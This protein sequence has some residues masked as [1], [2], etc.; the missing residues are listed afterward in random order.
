MLSDDKHVD[1][2]ADDFVHGLLSEDDANI[3][4]RH[5]EQCADC[6]TACER[7][8]ERK[9]TLESL[10]R[11]EASDELIRAAIGRAQSGSE[12]Q[13]TR[14]A[15]AKELRW[16]VYWS[17]VSAAAV[18]LLG[19]SI[20]FSTLR[21]SP[22]DLRVYGQRTLD[23]GASESLRVMLL[24]QE[25]ELPVE[26]AKIQIALESLDSQLQT[27]LASFTT[28]RHG[29]ASPE[30]QI[31]DWPAGRYRL[32]VRAQSGRRRDVVDRTIELRRAGKLM[33]SSD[34]PVYQPGQ[35]IHLRC[36]SLHIPDRTP[37]GGQVAEFT[38]R[39]PKG[40]MIFKH[41]TRTSRFGI[42]S[43]DCPLATELIEGSYQIGCSIG[44][45]TTS[46]LTV[47]V[48]PYVLP[49]FRVTASTD[50][51]YY[52]PGE[53]IR[54]QVNSR[55]FFGK[56]VA[57]DVDA[58]V[59]TTGVPTSELGTLAAKLDAE[60]DAELSLRLPEKLVGLPM[61]S[62]D[63]G[64]AV[65]IRVTDP[66]GQQQERTIRTIATAEPLRVEVVHES[67]RLV[68]GVANRIYLF[69]TYA[70]G[71]PASARMSIG[72]IP[73]EVR[74]NLLGVAM[75]ELTPETESYRL[76]VRA[77][78]DNELVA[79]E[80]VTLHADA[81]RDR[82]IMRTDRVVY[83][84]GD[85]VQIAILGSGQQPVF[86]DLLKDG[87][88]LLTK[89]VD[90]KDGRGQLDLDLPAELSGNLQL[91]GYRFTALDSPSLQ[92][93]TIVV[94]AANQVKLAATLD[95]D[96]YRPGDRATVKFQL[97]TE[98]G[99]PVVG[100]V[101]L[102]VVDEA[103]FSV[104][105]QRP[106]MEQTFF[107]LDS[108]LLEPGY[109]LYQSLPK[110]EGDDG[111]VDF[112]L[113]QQA[114]NARDNYVGVQ[115]RDRLRREIGNRRLEEITGRSGISQLV[116]EYD[117]TEEVA[118]RVIIGAAP[119]SLAARTY[120]GKVSETRSLR[121]EALDLVMLFWLLFA[122]VF[123]TGVVFFITR[124]LVQGMCVMGGLV[125]LVL[126]WPTINASRQF[127]SAGSA[128]GEDAVA[129]NT[130]PLDDAPA[131]P[132]LR[133]W[134][135]E[136]LM[137]RPEMITDER[138][139]L[140]VDVPLA[141][142]IT[143]WRL[144]ASAVTEAGL[145]GATDHRIRVFQPFFV[146]VNL[147]AALTRNDE[148]AVPVIVYNYESNAQAVELTLDDEP[149]FELLDEPTRR[150]QVEPG[151]VRSEYFRIRVAKVGKHDLTIQARSD[152][153]IGDAIKRTVRVNPN[154]QLIENVVSGAL[155]A[156]VEL[157]V[158][159]EADAVPGSAQSI[160]KVYPSSF[161]QLV[162]G[163]ESILRQ[164]H[165]CFEQTSSTTYPNV[166]ALDY[167]RRTE[168]SQPKVEAKARQYIH[169]GYQR[170]LTFEVSG[171][172]FDWFGNPPANQLLTA[173]GLMEFIDMAEVHDVDPAL[174][175]RTRQWLLSKRRDDGSWDPDEHRMHDDLAAATTEEMR[176]LK[177]TAYIAWAAFQ[178]DSSNASTTLQFLLRHEPAEIDSPY[179]LALVSNAILA[180]DPDCPAL[181]S[182]LDRLMSLR[183]GDVDEQTTYWAE[184]EGARTA[185]YGSGTA[186]EVEAT[187]LA[188]LAFMTANEQPS[189]VQQALS[190]LV[191]QKDPNGTWHSTQATVL[192]L[193]ALLAGT[194]GPVS[195][196]QTRLVELLM[197]DEV[198]HQFNIPAE[199]AEVVHQFVIA[200]D[201][202]GS[203]K[204]LSLR[205]TT[206]AS[207]AYQIVF[208]QH[209]EREP[210]SDVEGQPFKIDVQYDRTQLH[211]N[212]T[213]NATATVVN[214]TSANAPMLMVDL[215][216]PAGFGVGRDTLDRAQQNHEAI[217]KYEIT[218]RSIILYLRD[219]S[220]QE[221][222]Q[223]RYQLRALMPLRVTVPAARTYLYYDPS[224]K[225]EGSPQ[226]I[227]VDEA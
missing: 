53:M 206:G 120:P 5:C 139:Q 33:L 155:T 149:W 83:D 78:D 15:K 93:Q 193:K 171:G 75:I 182:Y 69:A 168:Q 2:Y 198:V 173:Y 184:P 100:A 144:T 227:V 81:R 4:R 41:R 221:S 38:I 147:P 129:A 111:S 181:T 30:M 178:A 68:P 115:Q 88:T 156:P 94:R 213:L 160:V 161:S 112:E 20:Y 118:K 96:E 126:L 116:R 6:Q 95:G 203:Q 131:M 43:T 194:Q 152:N 89:T 45:T 225:A 60:G 29:T 37:I 73:D 150:V 1:Q 190:W 3:F 80:E 148:V 216:I 67:G 24:N 145:L 166:L 97:S 192:A 56:S 207:T 85:T 153:G 7:A 54:I 212:E 26:D 195:S 186:G 141:D 12:I 42:A 142:S 172:G 220:S 218:P 219:L 210:R 189:I 18:L 196:D 17:A 215:P 99:Q 122:I 34:K 70:D 132:R 57:G 19:C 28:D 108:E 164:P 165:G 167:L 106:G 110:E 58:R 72:G 200:H 130:A 31:P 46:E 199:Q 128:V 169:L 71:Q 59:Y 87:Q 125:V 217:E 214:Q 113:V 124:T 201:Q 79:T 10:P 40:N 211:L 62:G 48:K 105:T 197:D 55:Y 127:K 25:T 52:R 103:V 208:R 82:F 16:K 35:T 64:I 50:R 22:Y 226:Q 202:V 76:R 138:G 134:F 9:E 133:E 187:A 27:R 157:P 104:M 74:T 205:E 117:L 136:T 23:A 176:R 119:H 170:L 121:R 179:V 63:L 223:I 140:V 102:A 32:V 11:P 86:I 123:V 175:K 177:T 49:K 92:T 191:A 137:W 65:D 84:G 109:V 135:P 183:L 163:L 107:E 39:D 44:K 162:E 66:A 14:F 114:A 13:P 36:L 51:S 91:C 204:R 224:Q 158:V 90:V 21:P 61:H 77:V 180:I 146:D 159:I 174:I 151:E 98:E 8:I 143:D 209:V 154:G 222:L 47:E 101:S 188:A 185:F